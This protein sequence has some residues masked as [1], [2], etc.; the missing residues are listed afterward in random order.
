[1]RERS[2]NE[3]PVKKS[4]VYP[5]GTRWEAQPDPHLYESEVTAMIR[6]MLQDPQIREDQ[7]WAWRRWRSGDNAIKQD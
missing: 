2:V 4:P 6:K 5:A 3:E 7:A 1:M